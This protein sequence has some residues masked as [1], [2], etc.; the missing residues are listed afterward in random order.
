MLVNEL[1]LEALVYWSLQIALH[2]TRRNTFSI[3]RLINM[4]GSEH[5]IIGTTCG[6]H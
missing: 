2:L 3:E 5:K 1:R 6:R 4:N